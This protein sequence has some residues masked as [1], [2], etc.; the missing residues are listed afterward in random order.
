ML[1]VGVYCFAVGLFI[2]IIC[3]SVYFCSNYDKGL[4]EQIDTVIITKPAEPIYIDTGK[5]KI[6]YRT[7]YIKKIDTIIVHNYG[8]GQDTIYTSPSFVARLDTIVNQDT[9]KIKYFYPENYFNFRLNRK[10]DTLRAITIFKD[11]VIFENKRS[12]WEYLATF[13]GGIVLG[14]L[15]VK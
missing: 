14:Y 6:V 4:N 10:F 12:W 13:A 7:K 15:I 8:N 11:K 3:S 9:F 1:K 2:G 5:A